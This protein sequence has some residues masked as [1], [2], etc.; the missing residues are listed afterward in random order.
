M[1]GSGEAK[2]SQWNLY[3]VHRKVQRKE[4]NV[5]LVVK[6]KLEAHQALDLASCR[7]FTD[8]VVL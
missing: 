1:K 6:S 4:G 8:C 7:Y 2:K 3:E 5:L